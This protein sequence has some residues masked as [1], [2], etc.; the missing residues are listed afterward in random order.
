MRLSLRILLPLPGV[1]LLLGACTAPSPKV[2]NLRQ[3]HYPDGRAK[4]VGDL[5]W[6]IE[7]LMVRAF[8]TTS[9]G[10][11][12]FIG[13]TQDAI[14]DPFKAC[15]ENLNGLAKCNREN[16]KTRATM[17]EMYTWLAGDCTYA[18]SR[19]RCARELGDLGVRAGAKSPIALAP[20]LTPATALEVGELVPLLFNEASPLI[21]GQDTPQL[22]KQLAD[23]C[24]EIDA[25]TLDREGARRMLRVTNL[26]LS[27]WRVERRE[28]VDPLLRLHL[29]LEKQCIALA[30][31]GLLADENPRVRAAAISSAVLV[32]KNSSPEILARAFQDR[33]PEVVIAGMRALEEHG[34]PRPSR[35]GDANR[36]FQSER[37]WLEQVVQYLRLGTGGELSVAGCQAMSRL[38]GEPRDLHPEVW[39]VWWEDH[40]SPAMGGPSGPR[41]PEGQ[42]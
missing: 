34:V 40:G 21:A 19:E 25:L 31:G 30:L 12:E 13:S 3:V 2:W 18:L 1:V 7:H 14:K 4:Y 9:L 8:D 10:T 29:D 36:Y 32:T 28:S 26:L 15:L 33:D 5:R 20:E 41:P 6:P 17:V 16:P 27:R 11:P 35:M 22:R 37:F 38:T 39:I 24:L 42:G 23:R